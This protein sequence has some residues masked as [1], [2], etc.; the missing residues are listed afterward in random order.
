M[1]SPSRGASCCSSTEAAGS[2]TCGCSIFG[3]DGKR[4]LPALRLGQR[5]GYSRDYDIHKLIKRRRLDLEKAGQLVAVMVAATAGVI[6]E[7]F[8]LDDIQSVLVNGEEQPWG[9]TIWIMNRLNELR[10]RGAHPQMKH[11]NVLQAVDKAIVKLGPQIAELNFQLGSYTDANGQQRR[12][13]RF[14]QNVILNVCTAIGGP[15]EHQLIHQANVASQSPIR[16]SAHLRPARRRPHVSIDR[17][18]IGARS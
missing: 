10:L 17:D 5:L 4:R 14:S 3:T 13:I 2:S 12:L 16:P 6:S 8:F 1:W 7:Q 9:D 11:F 18:S 15:V